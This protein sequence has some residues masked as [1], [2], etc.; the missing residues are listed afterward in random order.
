MRLISSLLVA[1]LAATTLTTSIAAA[2]G[3][4][5]ERVAPEPYVLAVTTHGLMQKGKWTHRAFVVLAENVEL[6][7]GA[8]KQLAPGTFDS[9][10]I[11]SVA[12]RTSPLE[13][14]LVGPAGTRVVKTAKQVALS[15][16]WKIGRDQSRLALEIPSITDDQFTI[17][18]VGRATDAMWQELPYE[19]ATADATW[20]LT[21]QGHTK[22]EYVAVRKIATDLDVIEYHLDG[23][24][25]FSVRHGDSE[26]GVGVGATL[27][28]FTTKGRSFLAINDKGQLGTLELPTRARS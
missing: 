13:V 3:G 7:A 20:W 5:G 25:R 12:A 16:S 11:A 19:Q 17:A 10:R 4:Y 18:I 9:T 22:P 15:H 28:A 1:T 26:V 6:E 21:K 23:E 8:W 24:S 2:C 27:G 14:T